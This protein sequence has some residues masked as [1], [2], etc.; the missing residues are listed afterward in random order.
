MRN[1]PIVSGKRV[2]IA[3]LAAELG[4]GVDAAAY[5]YKQLAAECK[6]TWRA[7]RNIDPAKTRP[8]PVVDGQ[9]TTFPAL[10][11]KL[12]ISSETARSRYH[13][14]AKE[15]PVTLKRLR[16][17]GRALTMARKRRAERDAR[18]I[19]ERQTRRRELVMVSARVAPNVSI[20]RIQ[21][22]AG[23]LK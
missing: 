5:R 23:A 3:K 20:Q 19:H 4:I 7:L 16:A 21:Q 1:H 11:G 15:G 14:L 10:A 17:L 2:T 9:R 6:V 8:R 13:R 22:I 12:N 18:I